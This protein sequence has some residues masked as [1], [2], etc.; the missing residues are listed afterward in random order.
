[1][2]ADEAITFLANGV[3]GVA[4][5]TVLALIFMVGALTAH[6]VIAAIKDFINER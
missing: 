3:V 1:M 4:A 6:V 5:L 2:K